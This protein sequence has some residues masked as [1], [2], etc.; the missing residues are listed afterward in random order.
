MKWL[1]R[2][3][4]LMRLLKD[5]SELFG[6]RLH[7]VRIDPNSGVT[8]IRGDFRAPALY[9]RVREIGQRVIGV[10]AVEAEGLTLLE[11]EQMQ[12]ATKPDRLVVTSEYQLLRAT[13]ERAAWSA[14]VGLR[15]KAMRAARN[16][17][18]ALSD[19]APRPSRNGGH[20]SK[21]G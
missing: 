10:N 18:R 8:H 9:R 7:A 11:R 21:E 12:T 6:C 17:W 16:T 1:K 2:E 4:D 14:S 5:D 3:A 19:T 20:D 13:Q 15:H